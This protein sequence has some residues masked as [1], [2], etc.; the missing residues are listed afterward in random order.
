MPRRPRI[1]TGG[2]AYHVLN[3]RIGRLPLFESPKPSFV[4]RSNT[5]KCGLPPI[6]SCQTIGIFS[7]GP[8]R[9]E[10]CRR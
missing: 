2:L 1:A 4:K 5:G 7:F 8:G 3:R 10:N 6:A 9:T